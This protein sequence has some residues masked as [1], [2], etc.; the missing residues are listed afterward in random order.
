MVWN[1]DRQRLKELVALV[2]P[3]RLVL[4]LSCRK[5]DGVYKVNTALCSASPPGRYTHRLNYRAL[6]LEVERPPVHINR[7]PLTA[8]P[9]ALREFLWACVCN[10]GGD[11]PVAGV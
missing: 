11:G 4:D 8:Q 9:A 5:Q 3:K 2:G 10:A 7:L 1:R 6:T